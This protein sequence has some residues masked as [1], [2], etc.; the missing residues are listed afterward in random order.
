M[1]KWIKTSEAALSKVYGN[2]ILF[3]TLTG[4][5]PDESY[6]ALELIK[7]KSLE[8]VD[9]DRILLPHYKFPEKF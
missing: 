7:P 8:Y 4:L 2:I 5:R 6:N 1:L 9:K 3:T